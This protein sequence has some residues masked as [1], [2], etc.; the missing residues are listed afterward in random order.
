MSQPILIADIQQYVATHL[1]SVF[2]TM[3]S[4]KAVPAP[5]DELTGERVTGTVGMAGEKVTG[6]VYLHLSAPFAG[7]AT[8]AM[9]G[10]PPEEPLGQSDINDVTGEVTNMIAGGLKSW[11][12][13]HGA[14]CALTTPAVIRGTSFA[15]T[16]KPGVEYLL[17][18]FECNQ[19]RGLIEVHVKF[20]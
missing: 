2:E 16:A 9:L 15:I 12:C 8:A 14:P 5:A 17:L 7:Q 18:G 10:L 3:L 6:L 1:E 4:M 20:N 13:D 11:L 19:S